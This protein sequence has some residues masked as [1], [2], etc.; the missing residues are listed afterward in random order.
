MRW[1]GHVLRMENSRLPRKFLLSEPEIGWKRSRGGQVMTWHRG[2][3]EATRKLAAVG[4]CRLPGWGPRD[5]AHKWLSTL[6]DMARD[7]CQWRSCCN[8]LIDLH[9]S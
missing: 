4:P 1:L 8:F 9:D 3:K 7:R 2:M 5:S 6:E